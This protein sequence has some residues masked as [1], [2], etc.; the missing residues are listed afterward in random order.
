MFVPKNEASYFKVD[1]MLKVEAIGA[2]MSFSGDTVDFPSFLELPWLL[3]DLMKM[4]REKFR[5]RS[6][7]LITNPQYV[8]RAE[9]LHKLS[10]SA[11]EAMKNIAKNQ[12]D[13][14]KPVSKILNTSTKMLK[15]Y[16]CMFYDYGLAFIRTNRVYIKDRGYWDFTIDIPEFDIKGFKME[17]LYFKYEE[18][19]ET[20]EAAFKLSWGDYGLD[21]DKDG[22][23]DARG[24]SMQITETTDSLLLLLNEF[25]AQMVNDPAF[26][27]ASV[28]AIESNGER[29]FESS[30]DESIDITNSIATNNY[31]R[32]MGLTGLGVDFKMVEGKLDKIIISAGVD[33][34]LPPLPLKI[35]EVTGGISDLTYIDENGHV[36]YKN[37]D[38]L[39]EMTCEM[40]DK[41]ETGIFKVEDLGYKIRPFNYFEG[42]GKVSMLDFKVGE[43][44]VFYD[45]KKQLFKAE[46]WKAGFPPFGKEGYVSLAIGGKDKLTFEGYAAMNF[47]VPDNPL[48]IPACLRKITVGGAEAGINEHRIAAKLKIGSKVDVPKIEPNRGWAGRLWNGIKKVGTA[49]VRACTKIGDSIV[50]G[51]MEVISYLNIEIGIGYDFDKKEFLW[52]SNVVVPHPTMRILRGDTLVKVF[53]V[54]EDTRKAYF[55]VDNNGADS[56]EFA[57]Y[58]PQPNS[59]LFNNHPQAKKVYFP[60]SKTTMIVVE[61]PAKGQ[62]E[63]RVNDSIY[64]GANIQVLYTNNTP[65]G[66]FISPAKVDTNK[67]KVEIKFNDIS[68]T[69][70][71]KLFITDTRE[72]YTGRE[73]TSFK[74]MN[75]ARI[76]FDYSGE[77][78]EP[79]MYY[80]YFVIKDGSDLPIMQYAPGA[81]LVTGNH[82]MPKPQNVKYNILRDSLYV[83][84]GRT[85]PAYVTY[86]TVYLTDLVNGKEQHLNMIPGDTVLKFNELIPGHRY[87][88]R[89][90]N[91]N[92]LF[93]YS[94]VATLPEFAFNRSQGNK[95]PVWAGAPYKQFRFK[96]YRMN[97]YG[98]DIVDPEGSPVNLEFVEN[99][100]KTMILKGDSVL[101]YPNPGDKGV[102]SFHAIASDGINRDTILLSML[103][104]P[105]SQEDV[106]LTFPSSNLYEADMMFLQIEDHQ[107]D[108]DSIRFTLMNWNTRDSAVLYAQRTGAG[109]YISSFELSFERRSEFSV[110]DGD[111]IVAFYTKDASEYAAFAFFNVNPQVIDN[112]PPDNITDLRISPIDGTKK[113][114]L[115]FTVP[116]DRLGNNS[117]LSNPWVYELRYN[118]LNLTTEDDYEESN[119]IERFNMKKAGETD[120]LIIELDDLYD[121]TWYNKVFFNLKAGDGRFKYGEMSN[122]VDYNFITGP[123]NVKASIDSTYTVSLTWN[124]P[125]VN[126]YDTTLSYYN[127]YRQ[128]NR[129]AY[130]L[131]GQSDTSLFSDS[132]NILLGTGTINYAVEAVYSKPSLI[133]NASYS[134]ELEVD[135]M[136]GV[137][138]HIKCDSIYIKGF[139]VSLDP[140]IDNFDNHFAET[141]SSGYAVMLYV[142][143]STYTLSISRNDTVLLT[144]TITI[145]QENYTFN[146][147]LRWPP[148][149]TG[150]DEG[151][152]REQHDIEVYPNPTR[153]IITVFLGK[154]AGKVQ[155]FWLLSANGSVMMTKTPKGNDSTLNIN[156]DSLT[157]GLYFLVLKTDTGLFD[158]KI[159]LMK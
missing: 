56:V 156:L 140:W 15:L 55:I 139:K 66:Y 101:W 10:K 134:N 87:V 102:Y 145:S 12:V 2:V 141:D 129:Y 82:L 16:D 71:V 91:F 120:T 95:S 40:I 21:Y 44:R 51:A 92:T 57:L 68:D 43:G 64:P 60:E 32:G 6:E 85:N 94:A 58:C 99:L 45:N 27:G 154:Y 77:G 133:T 23:P 38:F 39:I 110:H 86:T 90:V 132:L 97:R 17:K 147:N 26:R 78:L 62:W 69:I 83:H 119:R 76:K 152:I 106:S 73:I 136:S 142:H 34:P 65:G 104:D 84:W 67:S 108:L 79:G 42:G 150:T 3:G 123:S 114:M 148:V 100:P 54:N 138:V 61:A 11:N 126:R 28:E 157:S 80:Y 75:H 131:I 37:N 74:V 135:M 111:T 52:G 124:G 4:Q 107:S 49:T 46:I 9:E 30:Y 19:H 47:G 125:S 18:L 109:K 13:L 117:I 22:I 8:E 24:D 153:G 128:V 144:D 127:I 63:V 116:Y 143:N 158:K 81:L 155:E 159:N 53:P 36:K 7:D 118:F 98:L 41:A 20:I 88:I 89:A 103:V 25:R 96:E 35:S 105:I 121:I 31:R 14:P 70:D 151:N 130:E 5:N 115:I 146:Y 29:V 33:I 72:G 93:G 149:Y 1:S 112:I 113:V 48:V 50:Q 122:T 137:V 59:I